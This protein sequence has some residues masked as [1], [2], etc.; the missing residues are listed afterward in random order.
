[1]S[2]TRKDFIDLANRRGVFLR[3]HNITDPATVSVFVAD[4]IHS[5]IS[6]CKS[7]NPRFDELRFVDH[8]WDVAMGRRDVDG[9]KVVPKPLHS[10]P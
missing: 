5:D 1:M 7:Q 9:R 3:G 10:S 4:L 6:F 8:M 2:L